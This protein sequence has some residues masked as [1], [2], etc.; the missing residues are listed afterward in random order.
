ML[1][2]KNCD[3]ISPKHETG[4]DYDYTQVCKKCRKNFGIPDD[5]LRTVSIGG[6]ICGITGCH[7]E[8]DQYFYFGLDD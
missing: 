7:G 4:D 6:Y 8:A 3:D 5:P 1:S 2:P